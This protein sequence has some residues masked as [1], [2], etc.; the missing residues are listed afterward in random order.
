MQVQRFRTPKEVLYWTR[1]DIL[2]LLLMAL[3]PVFLFRVLGWRWVALPWLPISLIG[4]AVAFLVG[5]K[6]NASYD[7]SWEAR[8]IWGAIVNTSR[9]WSSSILSYIHGSESQSEEVRSIHLRLVKRHIAWLTALRFQ[10]RE[11]R[12][13]ESM[14]ER[15]NSELQN[16]FYFIEEYASSAGEELKKFLSEEEYAAVMES[17]NKASQILA[18]QSRDLNNLKSQGFIDRY[19][20]VDLQ[21][22]VAQ[23]YDEQGGCERIKT[24]PYPRQY[25]TINLF[26][27][28]IFT[29]LVPFGMLREFEELLGAEY[30][31]LSIPLT[32]VAGWIFTTMEK[33]GEASENPF[34]G[35][36]NDIPITQISRNIEIDLMEMIK[37][38]HSLKPKQPECG[39]LT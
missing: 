16:K 38:P 19:Q 5:F 34:E 21:K 36:A 18:L 2:Q 39:V 15:Y 31:W 8:R 3:I 32:V 30:V 23:L 35:G 24:F 29:F 1:R 4:T 7:R 10:L 22:I 37:E 12:Q 26:Y 13:W 28:H 17:S 11:P 27:I 20:H 33:V 14:K 25:A 6:N 9:G